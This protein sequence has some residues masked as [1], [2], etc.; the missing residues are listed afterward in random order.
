MPDLH[1]SPFRAELRRL[2]DPT[3]LLPVSEEAPAELE[4]GDADETPS[5]PRRLISAESAEQCAA[6]RVRAA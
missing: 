1:L 3:R 6:S 5:G 4:A 2:L